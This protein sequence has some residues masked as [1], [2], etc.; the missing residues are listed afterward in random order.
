MHDAA[1]LCLE[2]VAL[3][4]VFEKVAGGAAVHTFFEQSYVN[5]GDQLLAV[6]ACLGIPADRESVEL[7]NE[8]L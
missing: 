6:D 2:V 8:L 1:V 5:V 7:F 4:Q 3:S